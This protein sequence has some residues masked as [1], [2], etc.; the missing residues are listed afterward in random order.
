MLPTQA[1]IRVFVHHNTLHAFEDLPFRE[2]VQQGTK[3]Y[4]CHAYLPEDRY[5]EKLAHGRI[6]PQDLAAELIDDLGDDADHLIGFFGTRF[7]FR[8][9]MLQ[10]PLRLG[11]DAELRWLIAETDALRHFRSEASA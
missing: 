10:Y 8:L 3:T 9:A 1:P 2:A 5:R 6:L 4:G 11:P 7:H